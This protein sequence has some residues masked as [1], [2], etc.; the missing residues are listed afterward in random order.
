MLKSRVATKV[1]CICFVVVSL[2]A[3]G[4]WSAQL[5]AQAPAAA[6]DTAIVDYADQITRLVQKRQFD[7]LAKLSPPT[8]EGPVTKLKSW[9]DQYV[10]QI[11]KQEEQRQKQFDEAVAKAQDLLSR[12]KYDEAMDKVVAAYQIAKDQPGF[13]KT[14][15]V[16]DLTERVAAKAA[17]YEKKGQW[18]ESLQLYTDLHSLY[19][20][21]TRYKADM[22]RLARRSRLLLMYTPRTFF[23]MRKAALAKQERERAETQPGTQ[24]STQAASDDEPPTFTKWQ[25]RIEGVTSDMLRDA[26]DRARNDWVEETSYA[27]M[28][29][30]GLEALRLFLTT[31][32]LAKEFAGLGDAQARADFD[33]GLNAA[34]AKLNPKQDMAAADV[35]ETVSG[36]VTLSRATVKLPDQVIIM[37][38]TDGAMEKLDPFTAVIWPHEVDEFE[39]NM[40]GSFGGVGI[41]ISLENGQLKVIS[42]LEDTPAF[43]AGI[44]AGD[45][46]TA[47]NGKSTVGI[48][49]DQAVHSIMGKP[50]TNVT[51]KIKREGQTTEKEY[52]IT[53]A[54]IKVSSVKGFK[55][56]A[57]DTSKWDF[58]LDPDNKVGYIRITGFQEDTAQELESALEKL[59][60]AGMRGL[61]MDLR[62]NPGGLLNA[63]VAISD[64]FVD[65]GNIVMTKGRS[66]RTH[67]WR[68]DKNTLVPT[69]M[70]VVVL[71]NQYSASASE[72]FA[73]AMKDLNRGLIIGQRS[74]GKGSVQNLIPIG[75][76]GDSIAMMKLT[77]SYY[78][79]P[80][81]ES[82]HRRDGA[83]E[84]GVDPNINIELTPKQLGDLLKYRRDADIIHKNA[85]QPGTQKEAALDTQLD[86]ALLML[87]LQLVSSRS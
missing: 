84:W 85:T 78:Y 29:A 81:G 87:R 5:Q 58:M 74:F 6:T 70:P 31:P 23:E 64:M 37:E 28:T 2:V 16:K 17:D 56:D 86:T 47:I 32:E 13:L 1:A 36:I 54:V 83:R 62:F 8:E 53:R 24:P 61:I 35:V 39:K 59:Q 80:D 60:A 77:M 51:L 14:E 42:P 71:V 75:K 48:S 25:D 12:S 46:V 41:Q 38:F 11:K 3:A 30:G 55:R 40:K 63:A 15:W 45:V 34:L 52:V 49:I 66:T 19:E 72:I 7:E 82:L 10:T 73:G 4:V 68:A 65:H 33:K 69:N 50:G 26:I 20:I 79:L 27:A 44:E 22:Q 43:R 18:I 21:D 67:V 76:R 57:A 9:Q